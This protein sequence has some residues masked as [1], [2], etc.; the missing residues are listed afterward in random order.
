MASNASAQGVQDFVIVNST[1]VDVY[2]MYVSPHSSDD[3]G[4]DILGD[5]LLLDGDVATVEFDWSER[6]QWWDLMIMDGDENAVVWESIDLFSVY[7]V[8]L[9]Y[10]ETTGEAWAETES[11]AGGSAGGVSPV[12]QQQFTELSSALPAG[13]T[14]SGALLAGSLAAGESATLTVSLA[15]NRE[16]AIIGAC[17]EGCSDLDLTLFSEMG[18]PWVEDLLPDDVPMLEVETS[19]MGGA[20]EL[21]VTMVSCATARCEWGVQVYESR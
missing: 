18:A 12:I 6:A 1:G 21:E 10:D 11:V 15:F 13:V 14:P 20:L 17:D 9:F 5:E 8:T 19:Q 7:S 4:E 2:Y 3:W 16:Y